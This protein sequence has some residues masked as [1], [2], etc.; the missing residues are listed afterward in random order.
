MLPRHIVHVRAP[1]LAYP[2][3]GVTAA[4]LHFPRR[5]CPRTVLQHLLSR[6]P[7]DSTSSAE[8]RAAVYLG[9]TT[10]VQV[11]GSWEWQNCTLPVLVHSSV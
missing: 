1:S 6:P 8:E 5:G 4:S 2:S 9:L 3:C 11:R 10:P 7:P